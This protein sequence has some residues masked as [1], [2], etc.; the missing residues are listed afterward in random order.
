MKVYTGKRLRTG[1]AV[2]HVIQENGDSRLLPLGL[3]VF[4]HSPTGFEWGY[5]GSGP[6]QLALALLLDVINDKATAIQLHQEF[7]RKHISTLSRHREWRMTEKDILKAVYP[8][9]KGT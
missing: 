4:N 6:A 3:E 2:V 8:L 5:S 9:M 1:E 7:K